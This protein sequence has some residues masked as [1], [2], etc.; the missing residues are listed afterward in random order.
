MVKRRISRSVTQ[1]GEVGGNQD[2]GIYAPGGRIQDVL[3][4]RP[5]ANEQ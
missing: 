2:E 5:T 1:F 3:R 4:P